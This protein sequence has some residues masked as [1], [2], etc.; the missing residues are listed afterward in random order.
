MPWEFHG[1]GMEE[2]AGGSRAGVQAQLGLKGWAEPTRRGSPGGKAQP[3]LGCTS[4]WKL[5]LHRALPCGRDTGSSDQAWR[6]GCKPAPALSAPT[7]SRCTEHGS[8]APVPT[9]TCLCVQLSLQN[10][11]LIEKN[12]TLQERLRQAQVTAQP[13]PADTAQ[14]A[15]ELHGELA[16]C[17]QDLQSVYSIVTQRAQGKDPN[18]SLL[19]GI[20]C[21]C[22]SFPSCAVAQL[23]NSHRAWKVL[24]LGF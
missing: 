21:K 3:L 10:Q 17:L 24:F 16:S 19:L 22:I 11:E 4:S 23:S 8:A 13:L 5:L 15:Q 7:Q 14:L 20:H 9:D 18:L 6:A 12:L 1:D 2:P